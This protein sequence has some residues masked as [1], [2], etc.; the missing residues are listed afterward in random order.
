[1]FDLILNLKK[2]DVVAEASLEDLVDM[3]KNPGIIQ[4]QLVCSART[5]DKSSKKFKNIKESV[6]CFIPNFRHDG[7]VNI[8]TIKSPTGFLYI[9]VDE[10]IDVDFEQFNFVA[11]SWK[12]LSGV[13]RGILVAVK[14]MDKKGTD[15]KVLKSLIGT[16]S[17]MM[18]ISFDAN[19]ISRD[20][21]N[22]MSYDE[23]IYYNPNYEEIEIEL[24]VNKKVG[25]APTILS[26]TNRLRE[27]V[28][29]YDDSSYKGELRLSNLDE[30]LG[31]YE[32]GENEMFID[33]EDSKIQYTHIYVPKLI[34]VGERNPKMFKILSGIRALNPH[35]SGNRL[36]KLAQ[37]INSRVCITPIDELEL[38]EMVDKIIKREC[39]LYPNK[40]KR[41]IYNEEFMLTGRER[42]SIAAIE[43]NRKKTE[44]TNSR[45]VEIIENWDF[46][47]YPKLN[48]NC[49]AKVS[50]MNYRT[51][52]RKKEIL[53][54]I[55][56]E[57]LAQVGLV[58]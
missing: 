32:F 56:A 14:D 10:H 47:K 21:V 9:D 5:L 57:K 42:Q 23:D 2:R 26:T 52:T 28:L 17:N 30:F 33:L 55:V 53:R 51:I 41:F 50:G 49:I 25:H 48:Y 18:D 24:E 3:I 1:M 37:S 12:S 35:L 31:M 22:A 7:Y 13:G 6:P 27:D 39:K 36:A 44:K 43:N 40:T 29:D 58:S 16:I 8:S 4:K 34:N 20:R 46:E 11:A 19:A 54:K 15:L 45:L 38:L